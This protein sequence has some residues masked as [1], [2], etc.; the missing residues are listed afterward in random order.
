VR[1]V[2]VEE[3]QRAKAPGAPTGL[4]GR[5]AIHLALYFL[6]ASGPS[7]AWCWNRQVFTVLDALPFAGLGVLL[8]G[9]RKPLTL[10]AS[11]G[12]DLL[13]LADAYAID[14]YSRIFMALAAALLTTM[15]WLRLPDPDALPEV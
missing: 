8:F 9:L 13:V 6:P 2:L 5:L 14:D 1:E 4:P 10:L 3:H 15:F 11:L 7:S 12:V